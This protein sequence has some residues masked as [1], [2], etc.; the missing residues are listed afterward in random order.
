MSN[1]APEG[2]VN[3]LGDN[4]AGGLFDPVDFERKSTSEKV[5][6]ALRKAILSGQLAAGAHLPEGALADNFKVSRNTIR[7]A[8]QVLDRDGLVSH[9]LHRGAFVTELGA[10]DIRDVFAVR[11]LIELS[12]LQS[13]PSSEALGRLED[14]LARLREAV[15]G[16]DA[17]RIRDTQLEFHRVVAGL[18]G[19]E[20]LSGLFDETG[21][22]THL[23]MLLLGGGHPNPEALF[24]QHRR[25]VDS[26]N[27]GDLG[28]AREDLS[29]HLKLTEE[30]LFLAADRHGGARPEA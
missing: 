8:I 22:E 24:D 15:D 29:D 23:S 12:A 9:K 1:F 10:D 28:Q 3:E 11:R 18:N 7:G 26:L 20:R 27:R 16:G 21:A 5:A 2:H 4:Q 25:I 13:L 14:A 17:A 30:E 19:S 6:S